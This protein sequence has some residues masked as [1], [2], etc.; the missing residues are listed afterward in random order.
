M[1]AFDTGQTSVV[2]TWSSD[3]NDGGLELGSKRI[4]GW[5]SCSTNRVRVRT[6]LE[7]TRTHLVGYENGQWPNVCKEPHL[8]RALA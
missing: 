1:S 7:E 2:L 8:H 4:S 3:A 5:I 6:K